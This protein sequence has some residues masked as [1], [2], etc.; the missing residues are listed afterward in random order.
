MFN[1]TLR[2]IHHSRAL[3]LPV[4]ILALLPWAIPYITPTDEEFQ[5]YQPALAQGAWQSLWIVGVFFGIL[6]AANIGRMMEDNKINEHFST[7]G[8]SKP[9]Q[10]FGQ[11]RPI[12]LFSA[13]MGLIPLVICLVGAMPSESLDARMWITLQFQSLLLW[14]LCIP[15]WVAPALA[16]SNRLSSPVATVATLI[17][18][19]YGSYTLSYVDMIRRNITANQLFRDIAEVIWAV[20]PHI[21]FADL[22][23]RMI[24]KMGMFEASYFW[25]LA[26]YFA[27][28][29]AVVSILSMFIVKSRGAH[30]LGKA[31]RFNKTREKTYS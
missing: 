24:F 27:G 28:Y 23:D 20:S 18:Y 9:Q 6:S 13:L 15:L 11:L 3:W 8:L 17:L 7:M 21:H 22:T 10:F 25:S 4:L 12:W 14:I 1:F 26:I 5:I 19:A 31:K 29:S 16:L 30:A 2:T